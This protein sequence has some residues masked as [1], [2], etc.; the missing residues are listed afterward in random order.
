V[1]V[2]KLPPCVKLLWRHAVVGWG[3]IPQC[4]LLTFRAHDRLIYSVGWNVN[5]WFLGCRVSSCL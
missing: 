4:L 5:S 2:I 1:E 3:S